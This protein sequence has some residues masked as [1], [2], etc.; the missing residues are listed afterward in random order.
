MMKWLAEDDPIVHEAVKT[1]LKDI[2]RQQASTTKND[3]EYVISRRGSDTSFARL[4][5]ERSNGVY[6]ASNSKGAPNLLKFD[7]YWRRE[8]DKLL[9]TDILKLVPEFDRKLVRVRYRK[10]GGLW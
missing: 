7:M 1:R 10:L 2:S 4:L 3:V 6:V 8:A 9:V 5:V